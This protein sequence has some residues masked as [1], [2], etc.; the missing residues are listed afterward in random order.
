MLYKVHAAQKWGNASR[1][2]GIVP[3]KISTNPRSWHKQVSFC[4]P[5]K[6]FAGMRTAGELL[7]LFKMT[8]RK[9]Y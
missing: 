8:G 3:E 1:K 7:E 9:M 5:T 6:S 2:P 4:P